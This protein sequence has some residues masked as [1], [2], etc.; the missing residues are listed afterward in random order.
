MTEPSPQRLHV[1][2]FFE[3]L[4]YWRGTNLPEQR[5]LELAR[6]DASLKYPLGPEKLK[7]V[8]EYLARRVKPAERSPRPDLTTLPDLPEVD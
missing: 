6:A 1:I 4:E 8:D 5:C 2:H 7:P 3:R